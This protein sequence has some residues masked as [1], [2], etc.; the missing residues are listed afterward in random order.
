MEPPPGEATM[1]TKVIAF[2]T[3]AILLML[4]AT[5][6]YGQDVPP[7][8]HAFYG[9]VKIN[10]SPAPVGTQVEA[11][12]EGVRASIEG[13]PIVTIAAGVYGSPDPMGPKLVVQGNI[14]DGATLTFYVNG[15]QVGQT[16]AWHSGE[17]TKLDLTATIEGPPPAPPV[18]PAPPGGGGGG[19]GRDT[20]P[21]VISDVAVSNI[22]KTS[23]D[24]G[25]K[26]DE[27]SDSQVEYWSSPSTLTLLDTEMVIKHLI[28]L[29]ELAP[30]STY[31]FRVRSA[32][33]ASNLAVS[34]EHTF[35]TL[36]KA[37]AFTSSRLSISPS[38]VYIGETVTISVVI[39]N[40]GD[41]AGS[42]GVSLK[43][44]GKV[45]ATKEITLNAGASKEVTF[46][47]AKDVA[48]SYS[49]E[50]DGL[51]G[52]FAV[53]GKPA[54]PPPPPTVPPPVIPPAPAIN[55][56]LIWGIVGGVVVVGIIIFLVARRRGA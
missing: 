20:T 51:S 27:D 36:V 39:A 1:K 23:A 50:V 28:H 54:P 5:P 24:V 49:V 33:V 19:G 13:N 12:G 10:D 34:E 22:T 18:P 47:A 7:L 37:A 32:D 21:P 35:T 31:Y 14:L 56:P 9:T 4:W 26:T 15:V 2:V 6:A 17:V 16:A 11:R 52:S 30:G 40:T 48:G 43:I 38:E 3:L 46:T 41:G 55:W 25:W 44:N 8:P 29:A 42:Y 53:K 45:E